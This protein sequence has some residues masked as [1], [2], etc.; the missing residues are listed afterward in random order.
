MAHNQY[1]NHTDTRHTS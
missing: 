1:N